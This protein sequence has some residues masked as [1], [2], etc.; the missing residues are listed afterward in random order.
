MGMDPYLWAMCNEPE[1]GKRLPSLTALQVV[2]P[3]E[4]SME[5]VLVDK[6]A[7][8]SLKQ[9]ENRALELYHASETKLELVEKLAGLVSGFMGYVHDNFCPT[10]WKLS[11]SC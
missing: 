2:D 8:P 4:S 5:V 3:S 9:L 10:T 11:I 6:Y 7:D 1:V